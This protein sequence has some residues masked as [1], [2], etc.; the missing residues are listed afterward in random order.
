MVVYEEKRRCVYLTGDPAY[1]SHRLVFV[2][3]SAMARGRGV[4]LGEN[5]NNLHF[6]YGA[7]Q[8]KRVEHKK[9]TDNISA[10]L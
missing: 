1:Y 4:A 9:G 6:C 8:Q 3:A 2:G 7:I 10:L 5:N